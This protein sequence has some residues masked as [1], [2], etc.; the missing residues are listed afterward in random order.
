MAKKKTEPAP[1][2]AA[3][4]PAAAPMPG[5]PMP[6]GMPGM[7]GMQPGMPGMQP[8]NPM[9]AMMQMMQMMMG[10]G[11]APAVMDPAAMPF[12]APAPVADTVVVDCC[13]QPRNAVCSFNQFARAPLH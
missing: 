1:A 7:P 5:M 3:P 9:M 4:A 10:G 11:L 8:G 13:E 12:A 2:P 6:A